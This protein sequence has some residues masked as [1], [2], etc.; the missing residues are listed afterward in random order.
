MERE[1]VEIDH[2]ILDR[3]RTPRGGWNRAQ[4]AVL[5]VNWPPPNGWKRRQV[6]RK[7][8]RDVLDQFVELRLVNRNGGGAR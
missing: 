5:G 6:G 8:S 7:V 1:Q 4:L 2:E 3:A